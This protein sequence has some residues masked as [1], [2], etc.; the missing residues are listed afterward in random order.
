MH[1]TG[2]TSGGVEHGGDREEDE[3]VICEIVCLNRGFANLLVPFISLIVYA[4]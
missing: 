3:F 2:W 1:R 4:T